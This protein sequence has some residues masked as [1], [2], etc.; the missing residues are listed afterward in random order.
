MKSI[1]VC[2]LM[3]ALVVLAPTVASQEGVLP[4]LKDLGILDDEPAEILLKGIEFDGNTVF[5]DAELLEL[6]KDRIGK[7]VSIEE[8]EGVRKTISK[9]YFDQ[10]YV[11]SG[12]VIDE[13][14]LAAGVLKIRIVE[15]RLND[16]NVMN[17]GGW[18]R[19]DYLDKRIHR[20][21][22]KPL[23]LD[24]LKLALELIRRDD[25]IR[26]I[27]T[28][29]VPT[30]QLGESNLDM[31]VTE[32]KVFD[33]GVGVSNRRPPS[34]GAEEAEVFLGTKNLTSLGDALRANYTFT[35]EGMEEVDFG[36]AGNYSVF[37]SLPLTRWDTTLELGLTQSDYAILEEP[38]DALDIESDTRMYTVALRQPIYRDFQH[39]F[40]VTL[41]G[42]HRRSEVLVSGERFSISP[43]SVDGQTRIT[44]LRISPEYV[45]RSQERV[46]AARTTL[47]FGLDELD[48]IMTSDYD[49]KYLTWLTQASWVESVSSN[50]MLFIV[51]LFHQY[52]DQSVVSMEQFSLGGMN[53][54]RGYRENQ[55][56]R[57]NAVVISPELRIPVYKDRY[58]KA[59]VYLIPFFDYG[60]GWNTDGPRGRET[61]YSAGLGVTYN[62][63]DYVN[64]AV[65]WGH[66]FE[67]F[68]IPND[69]DLQD[70]G[71]HFQL[72][73]GTDFW[74]PTHYIGPLK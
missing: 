67:D 72:R 21:V 71:I 61:I 47:S 23:N 16:V 55:L 4:A 38:F 32:N 65:Y 50:D 69:D 5:S 6:V 73:I 8:L 2:R 24:D 56:I 63:T 44:A 20:E 70:Y 33:A 10:R 49:R 31:I 29:L 1:A 57:D 58:G 45:Y 37:Y 14:D 66:A 26:K 22:G 46:I 25:K 27:N 7:K 68:D 59:L 42:E 74:D 34:V 9:H 28:A 64:M 13:Q 12:A 30:D 17:K 54:I 41:K 19:T 60:V 48:P 11:N 36:D 53:T 18:L 15:G 3:L 39:E 43:G 35:Q 51:K 40:S 52:T 62:P